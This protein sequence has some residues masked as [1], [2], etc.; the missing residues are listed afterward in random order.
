[1][2]VF[3]INFGLICVQIDGVYDN[4]HLN[5]NRISLCRPSDTYVN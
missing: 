3:E 1:M 2:L 4:A 5:K